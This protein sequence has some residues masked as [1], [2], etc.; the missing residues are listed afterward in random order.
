MYPPSILRVL[1]FHMKIYNKWGKLI[2]TGSSLDQVWDG[3]YEGVLLAPG[4]YVYQ[5]AYTGIVRD[6]ETSFSKTDSFYLIR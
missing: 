2:F 4:Q 5:I 1:T 3:T 6:V